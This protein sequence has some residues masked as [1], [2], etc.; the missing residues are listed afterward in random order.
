[1]L[2]VFPARSRGASTAVRTTE[3]D[4]DANMDQDDVEQKFHSVMDQDTE[5]RQT[6][7]VHDVPNTI[8]EATAK[9]TEDV[10]GNLNLN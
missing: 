9:E 2:F 6:E 4:S 10:T 3:S 7:S 8:P 5:N 1:M